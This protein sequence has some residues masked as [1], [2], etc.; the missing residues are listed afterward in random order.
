[1]FIGAVPNEVVQQMLAT[2]RFDEW[3]DVF[4]G[5]SGSFRVD[6][7]VKMRHPQVRVHSNDVSLL[8]CSIGALAMRRE[9]DIRFKGALQ[10]VEEMLQDASFETRVAAVMVACAMGQ[11]TGKNEF[12]R[13][14]FEHYRKRFAE[15]TADA[16]ERLQKLVSEVQI[17]EFHAGD[18]RLQIDR[19]EKVGGGFACFAPTYKGGY[20][21]LYRLVNENTEW[22][23]PEYGMWDPRQLPALMDDL[24]RRGIPYCVFSD[25]LLEGRSPNTEFR[26]SNKPVFTYAR[27]RGASFRRR[28]AREQ[29]F[30]YTPI[31]AAAIGPGSKVEV[32]IADGAQ[33]NYLKNVYLAKGIQ[34]TSGQMNYLVF[35][36]GQ[37]VGG[38]IF[39]Q[40]KFGDR[41]RELYLLSDFSISR[42]RK[43]SKLV[44]M[45]ATSRD[46]IRPI[47][48]KMLVDIQELK[49]TAFTTAPVSMKYRGIYELTKR[50]DD[51]LQYSARV[52]DESLQEVFDEWFQRY[53]TVEEG[54]G[55]AGRAGRPT[56]GG[57][58]GGGGEGGRK[59]GGPGDADRPPQAV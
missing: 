46:V 38:F 45:L 6:R 18:F 39:T 30:K 19:A 52:R 57:R 48:R 26:G 9:F 27:E 42:E 23:P 36:D 53:G 3:R 44:A 7:A 47:N 13:S 56:A 12:A 8:T 54:K 11:Y 49:T 17:E 20:E 51:H 40:S 10:F 5:C 50:A 59:P 32:R 2:V 34:H 33:M 37:L 58:Q 15:F 25:T 21:R 28:V 16:A 14:H 4:I 29:R 31:D 43:L 41:T 35:V 55:Q 24:D 22:T 1:M